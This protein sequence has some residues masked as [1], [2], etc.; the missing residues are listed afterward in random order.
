MI[1]ELWERL[2]GYDKWPETSARFET[3]DLEKTAHT[4]RAGNVSYT[5]A[6]QDTIIWIDRLG[7]THRASFRVPDDSPIYQMIDGD[8]VTIRYNPAKPDHY[9]YRELLKTRI[10]TAVKYTFWGLIFLALIGLRVWLGRKN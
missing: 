3:A 1:I 9:Y 10:A 8:T 6:S 7:S 2:L 4:D 5:W